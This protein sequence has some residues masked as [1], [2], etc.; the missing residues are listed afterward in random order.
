MSN[1]SIENILKHNN[2]TLF[3]TSEFGSERG[4]N[5]Y[6]S[7]ILNQFDRLSQISDNPNNFNVLKDKEDCKTVKIE[8]KNKIIEDENKSLKNE[9]SEDESK[10][11]KN[12]E[13]DRN[14]E[15]EDLTLPIIKRLL[16]IIEKKK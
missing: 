5:S 6:V 13:S 11:P 12:E 4:N 7:R 16:E 3:Q 15:Q 1:I 2:S 10:S 14:V 9:E 8:G